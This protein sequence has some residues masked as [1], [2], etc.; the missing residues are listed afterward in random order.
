[1]GRYFIVVDDIWDATAWTI[2]RCALPDNKNGSRVIATTRIET[3][4]RTCSSNQDEYV[5]KMK[6][7]GTKDS[8][9]LFFKRIFSSHDTCPQYLEEVSTAILKKCGGLP[10][11]IITVS[12]HLATQQNNQK[13]EQWEH[14]LNYLGSNL[15]LNPTLEG[16]RQILSLSYTNLPHCLKTCVL[17]LGLYPEDHTIRKNDLVRQWVCDI[18]TQGLIG[19][20]EYSYHQG[21]PS[22]PEAH[23]Q[24]TSGLSVLARSNFRMGNRPGSF[25]GCAQVSTK[26]CRKD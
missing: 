11:A 24:R 22:F 21:I 17:Y 5:Y 6:A 2:I 10:L 1:L 13:N 19:L 12:S 23:L 26:V 14:T 18:L 20:I 9:K 7:L 4:A 25:F 16:M 8:R 15:E 3:V